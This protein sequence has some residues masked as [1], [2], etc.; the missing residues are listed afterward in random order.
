METRAVWSLDFM[1]DALRDGRRFRV[2]NVLD[3]YNRRPICSRAAGTVEIDYSLPAGRVV[4]LLQRLVDTYGKLAKLRCDSG[5][6]PMRLEFISVLLREWC[7][8]N[9]VGLHW[10]QPGKPTQ[11][12]YVERFDAWPPVGQL[13]ARSIECVFVC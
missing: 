7:E 11:N 6:P 1:S 3:D 8:Q 10:I 2:L 13:S 12:T 9:S 4:R 5:G